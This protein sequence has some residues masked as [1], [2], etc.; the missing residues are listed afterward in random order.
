MNSD[1][2]ILKTVIIFAIGCKGMENNVNDI[3]IRT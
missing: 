3:R 2:Q 1:S